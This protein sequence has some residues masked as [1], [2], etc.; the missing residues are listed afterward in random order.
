M[1]DAGVVTAKTLEVKVSRQN[2]GL[3]RL[4]FVIYDRNTN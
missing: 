1:L 2:K 4:S 3:Y